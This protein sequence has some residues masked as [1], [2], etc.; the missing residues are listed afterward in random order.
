MKG[1]ITENCNRKGWLLLDTVSRIHFVCYRHDEERSVTRDDGRRPLHRKIDALDA[2]LCPWPAWLVDAA[3]DHYS[4]IRL[5]IYICEAWE[6][7]RLHGRITTTA[8]LQKA[9][10]RPPISDNPFSL[11]L[12]LGWCERRIIKGSVAAAAA[13]LDISGGV[14]PRPCLLGEK[15][16]SRSSGHGCEK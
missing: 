7:D 4:A 5:Y 14:P 3:A 11:L 2:S 1:F 15:R 8:A 16:S 9:C 13:L 10:W 12:F 6:S